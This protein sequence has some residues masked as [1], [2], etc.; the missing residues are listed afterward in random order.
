MKRKQPKQSGTPA[1]PEMV[2]FRLAAESKAQLEVIAASRELCV[3][4]VLRDAVRLYLKGSEL[5]KLA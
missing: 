5:L 4:D 1:L 3:S 2:K